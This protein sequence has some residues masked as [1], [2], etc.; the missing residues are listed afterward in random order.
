MAI[1]YGRKR[2]GIAVTD[3]LQIVA[4]ALI[5]ISSSE[6]LAFLSD[7]FK[8][9]R[10]ET[11]VVGYP[12]QLNNKPSEAVLYVNDFL[13]RFERA[14]PDIPLVQFDER[15]TSKIAFQAMIDAGLSRKKRRDKSI[16]DRVSATLILQSYLESKANL[17]NLNK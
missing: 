6:V 11:V 1:D 3:P 16:V 14:F 5:S 12:V 13:K 7:Y 2:V 10:V 8:K 4:N 15:F 9:E 17:S